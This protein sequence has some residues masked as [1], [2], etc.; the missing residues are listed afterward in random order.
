MNKRLLSAA[1]IGFAVTATG[2]VGS[3]AT[4][5]TSLEIQSFQSKSFETSKN[6]AFASVVS[7]FQDL[8]YIIK[9]ADKD[10]GFITAQSAAKGSST[11]KKIMLGVSSSSKTNAT[12]FIEEIVKGN[13]KIRLNFVSS[14]SSSSQYGQNS[15]EENVI[16]DPKAYQVAFNKIGDAIFIRSGN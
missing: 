12:A 1:V 2:C 16:D 7:V 13:T 11:F 10:T 6:V 4:T 5:K 3:K 15:T 8:G 9:S 14:I